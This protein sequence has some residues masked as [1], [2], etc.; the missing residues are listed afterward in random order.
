[1]RCRHHD[2]RRAIVACAR[3][4]RDG[5]R[6]EL[7]VAA[8]LCALAGACGDPSPVG[9]DGSGGSASDGSSTGP[10]ATSVVDGSSSS[11]SGSDTTGSDTS[12]EP[13]PECVMLEWVLTSEAAETSRALSV[14]I[15]G[16]VVVVLERRSEDVPRLYLHGIQLD[17]SAAF[18]PVLVGDAGE[19]NVAPLPGGGVAVVASGSLVSTLSWW[20]TQGEPIGEVELLAQDEPIVGLVVLGMPDGSIVV[21]GTANATEQAVLQGRSP[22]GDVVWEQPG[23]HSIVMALALGS[24]GEILALTANPFIEGFESFVEAHAPDGSLQWS[25]LAGSEGG[26]FNES[27][28]PHALTEGGGGGAVVLGSHAAAGRPTVHSARV[29]RFADGS[30][31][32]SVLAPLLPQ[33]AYPAFGAIARVGEQ[34]VSLSGAGR[35]TLSV[36]DLD[37]EVRCQQWIGEAEATLWV[38]AMRPVSDVGFVV[39]G[40]MSGEPEHAWV[41][42][43]AGPSG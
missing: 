41:A 42:S 43:F 31:A 27:I 9:V 32:W 24:T 34:L 36:H 14:A 21:G 11:G 13:Q 15:D 22:M 28:A 25:V 18:G 19:G 20:S 39:V 8:W 2:G 38:Q 3:P 12:I 5:G 6:S 26:N 7:V 29:V 4:V 35:P 33:T 37:G 10:G 1:M 16:D 30:E 40:S 23:E 17:G